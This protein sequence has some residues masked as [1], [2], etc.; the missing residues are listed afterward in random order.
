MDHPSLKECSLSPPHCLDIAGRRKEHPEQIQHWP[1]RSTSSYFLVSKTRNSMIA[2]TVHHR[3]DLEL[4]L[5]VGGNSDNEA[6]E[7]RPI[8][9]LKLV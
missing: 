1:L 9:L 7:F 3:R 2:D 4:A 6:P 8:S 5:A